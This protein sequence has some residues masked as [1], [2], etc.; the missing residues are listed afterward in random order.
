MAFMFGDGDTASKRIVHS[1]C[2]KLVTYKKVAG[3]IAKTA[4]GE[5]IAD[6]KYKYTGPWKIRNT[7]LAG[8]DLLQD[9][10]GTVDKLVE[11]VDQ[12][13][14]AKSNEWAEQDF[15]KSAYV[16]YTGLVNA[17]IT[18]SGPLIKRPADLLLNYSDYMKFMH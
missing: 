12:V 14:Q 16:W 17:A 8:S 4:D 9:S 7:Q 10:L 6:D 5:K 1:L 11:Y 15:R 13:V 18:A 2:D 3:K